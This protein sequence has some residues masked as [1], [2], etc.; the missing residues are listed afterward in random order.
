VGGF[1]SSG[2]TKFFSVIFV[3]CASPKLETSEDKIRFVAKEC[4]FVQGR[5]SDSIEQVGLPDGHNDAL[6]LR[7]EKEIKAGVARPA[8][9]RPEFGAP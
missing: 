7:L 1:T 8:W 9:W 3:G 6:L 2:F 5:E 4:C